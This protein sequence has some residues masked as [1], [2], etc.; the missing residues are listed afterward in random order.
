LS[1]L[2]VFDGVPSSVLQDIASIMERRTY[3]LGEFVFKQGEPADA[4]YALTKGAVRLVRQMEIPDRFARLRRAV[5]NFRAL[6][7]AL[8]FV[9]HDI[10][11]WYCELP[12]G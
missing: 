6:E 11:L 4:M 10:L 2:P 8:S 7:M 12:H 9:Y 5:R 3:A 1:Q